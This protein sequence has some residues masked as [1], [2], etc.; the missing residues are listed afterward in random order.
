MVKSSTTIKYHY[1]E[2]GVGYLICMTVL[3]FTSLATAMKVKDGQVTL[4]KMEDFK[5]CTSE[6]PLTRCQ[7]ALVKWIELH[8]EDSFTASRL[9]QIELGTELSVP[10]FSKAIDSKK[11]DCKDGTLKKFTVEALR[12]SATTAGANVGQKIGFDLCFAETKEALIA[13]VDTSKPTDYMKNVCPQLLK[14]KAL[15]SLKMKYCEAV[16]NKAS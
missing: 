1:K 15:K 11:I 5:A 3:F 12:M 7:A 6:Q 4:E 8:P 13:G 16:V 10:L 9:G 14:L 2:M